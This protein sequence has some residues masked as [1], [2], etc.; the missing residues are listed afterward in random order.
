MLCCTSASFIRVLNALK[1][2]SLSPACFIS[3]FYRIFLYKL[4]HSEVGLLMKTVNPW[5]ASHHLMD[6][7]SFLKGFYRLS[8]LQQAVLLGNLDENELTLEILRPDANLSSRVRANLTST[9]KKSLSSKWFDSLGEGEDIRS[10]SASGI[11]IMP[12]LAHWTA[13]QLDVDTA[14]AQKLRRQ[15]GKSAGF[16]GSSGNSLRGDDDSVLDMDNSID[17]GSVVSGVTMTK[18]DHIVGPIVPM[19]PHELDGVNPYEDWG[20]KE[21]GFLPAWYHASRPSTRTNLNT[22]VRSSTSVSTAAS[23]SPSRSSASL[24]TP[25]VSKGKPVSLSPIRVAVSVDTSVSTNLLLTAEGDPQGPRDEIHFS[26]LNA[27][28]VTDSSSSGSPAITTGRGPFPSSNS[29]NKNAV[30]GD[31]ETGPPTQGNLA[32]GFEALQPGRNQPPRGFSVSPSSMTRSL[33]SSRSV[34]SLDDVVDCLLTHSLGST[35]SFLV[36]KPTM[37]S[38]TDAG[39]SSDRHKCEEESKVK[40]RKG[41]SRI[42]KPSLPKTFSAVGLARQEVREKLQLQPLQPLN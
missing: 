35:N 12:R 40:V 13:H 14:S 2:P 8:R 18:D 16:P 3:N 29:D 25:K 24:I 10:T 9:D 6:G 39:S 22:P 1:I 27:V 28:S 20:L 33:N 26:I 34:S 31:N 7:A 32:E 21:A 19:L 17:D 11:R 41:L 23:G 38:S 4:S 36:S 30:H 5:A 15:H 42:L 37:Q